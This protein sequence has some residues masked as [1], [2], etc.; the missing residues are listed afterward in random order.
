MGKLIA[1]TGYTTRTY[2]L[3]GFSI[4]VGQLI[5]VVIP[6]MIQHEEHGTTYDIFLPQIS[7]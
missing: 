5:L 1:R 4:K 7:D 6:I 2:R 3:V